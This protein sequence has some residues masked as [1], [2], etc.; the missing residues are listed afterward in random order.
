[1]MPLSIGDRVRPGAYT[2]WARFRRSV[3]FMR[4]DDVVCLVAEDLGGG[5]LNIV[6]RDFEAPEARRLVVADEGLEWGARRWAVVAAERPDSVLRVAA[7][8]A[9]ALRA[10]WD[11]ARARVARQAAPESMAFVLDP[12][13]RTAARAPFEAAL[14]RRLQAGADRVRRG[15]LAA[16]IALL[17]GCGRGLTP[18]GDDFMAG[19]LLGLHLLEQAGAGPYAKVRQGVLDAARGDNPLANAF[20]QMAAQGRAARPLQRLA[21]ALADPDSAAL[22]AA[23]NGQ[24]AMGA[25]SGADLLVGLLVTL[26]REDWIWP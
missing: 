10:R 21:E 17:K 3:V 20:L 13:E 24:L 19:V 25:T 9:R 5:P 16:G 15:D 1:M 11:R 4:G 14:R 6:F 7:P 18:A 12:P 2:P 26:E 22:D 8:S 23:L